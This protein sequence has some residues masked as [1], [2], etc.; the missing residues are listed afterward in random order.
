MWQ[1]RSNG[2]VN[3]A[4]PFAGPLPRLA[5]P[6]IATI[7]PLWIVAESFFFT[8]FMMILVLEIDKYC[9]QYYA[10]TVMTT[11]LLN[12]SHCK[13]CSSFWKWAITRWH[14]ERVL[15]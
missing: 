4:V 11:Q 5:T 2:N 6:N 7:P 12:K 9:H 3:V 13:K 15:V 10:A 8:N 1:T 14:I